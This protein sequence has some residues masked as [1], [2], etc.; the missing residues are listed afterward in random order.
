MPGVVE[1]GLFLGIADAAIIAGP[2]GVVVLER[3]DDARNGLGS[4]SPW[5]EA[6]YDSRGSC[7]CGGVKYRI[8]GKLA[9]ALNCHCSMCR[10]AQGAAFRSRAAVRAADFEWVQGETLLTFYEFLARQPQG[11]LPHLR[12]ADPQQV[13]RTPCQLRLAARPPG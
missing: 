8:T 6:G 1:N 10:K 5:L 2:D 11:L 3:D 9:K 7:L 4:A 12:F 13:R